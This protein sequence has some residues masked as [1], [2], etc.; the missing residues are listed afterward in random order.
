LRVVER[1]RNLETMTWTEIEAQR[2]S[3][4]WNGIGDLCRDAARRLEE[5][6][7]DDQEPYQLQVTGSERVWGIRDGRTFGILWWD[8][9]HSVFPTAKRNT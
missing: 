9:D 1:L 6:K 2:S 5:L 3:H 7:L 8:P 4:G